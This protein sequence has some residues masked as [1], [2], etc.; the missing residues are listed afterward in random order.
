MADVGTEGLTALK[1]AK[2]FGSVWLFNMFLE[3]FNER[4]VEQFQVYLADYTVE[5][6]KDM[7][8][9]KRYPSLDPDIF[10]NLHGFETYLQTIKPKHIF[11]ALNDAR[12][13]LAE[14][15]YNM[16]GPDIPL[17][18]KPGLLYIKDFRNYFLEQCLGADTIPESAEELA[19]QPQ[20]EMV[21]AKCESCK[22]TWPVP[23]DEFENIREC[24]FCHEGKDQPPPPPA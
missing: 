10:R 14:G 16:G 5:T 4:I 6:F 22:S 9:Q 15:L 19:V 21:I 13:D 3:V 11:E 17:E 1:K 20:K 7:V 24:P 12:P 18:E 8:T 23:K 2:K